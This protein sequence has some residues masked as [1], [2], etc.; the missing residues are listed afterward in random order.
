MLRTVALTVLLR[1]AAACSTI[2]AAPIAGAA[3]PTYYQQLFKIMSPAAAS[4][5]APVGYMQACRARACS[6]AFN[7]FAVLNV[8]A[9]LRSV[10][11]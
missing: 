8:V 1:A 5:A 7:R 2:T 3:G 10:R 11:K 4:Y 9:K 6:K